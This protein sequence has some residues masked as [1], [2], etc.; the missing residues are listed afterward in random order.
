MAVFTSQA[1]GKQSMEISISTQ[2]RQITRSPRLAAL[3]G[4][5][6]FAILLAGMALHAATPPVSTDLPGVAI[7]AT[8]P[9]ALAGTSSGAFTLVRSGSADADLAVNLD[10]SG[11]AA[12]GVDYSAIATVQ[13]IPAGYF[14]L[15][16]PVQ[17]I[18]SGTPGTNKTVILTLQTNASY[19]VGDGRRA[20]VL[21]VQD[22][23]NYP[24]PTVTVTSPTDGSAFTLPC[25][26]TISAD[27]SGFTGGPL[28]GVSFFADDALLGRITTIPYSLIWTNPHAGPHAIFA[29]AV[30]SL[31]RTTL[32][33]PVHITVSELRPSVKLISP[34]NGMH[35]DAQ[36]DI[37][38]LAAAGEDGGT[39]QAVNFYANGHR[40]GTATDSPYSL[41]WPNVPAGLYAVAAIATDQAGHIG[42]SAPVAIIVGRPRDIHPGAVVN[43]H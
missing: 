19:H 39:I 9:T 40:L 7:L 34:T 15:D 20:T 13:T 33:T 35:F 27:A 26:V 6:G 17:P 5:A 25:N 32:S 11:T 24:A 38:L 10:I 29:R 42:Y 23:Y 21:I 16:I 37:T 18:V 3:T 41:V 2:S 14:A 22:T 43:S 12:N 28:Q 4:L 1:K 31:G 8:D 30:D 36:S